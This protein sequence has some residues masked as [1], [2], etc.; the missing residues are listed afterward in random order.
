MRV[1]HAFESVL[2]DSLDLTKVQ[3]SHWNAEHVV[4]DVTDTP[5]SI[6]NFQ[7]TPI[8]S[9]VP[10]FAGIMQ[11]INLTPVPFGINGTDVDHWL[12]LSG[13]TGT[14]EAVKIVG[15]TAISGAASGTISFI[16]AFNHTGTW[17][18]SSA[19][20]GLQEGV[21]ASEKPNLFIPPGFHN[22]YASTTIKDGTHIYGCGASSKLVGAAPNLT[23]IKRIVNVG[24]FADMLFENFYMGVPTQFASSNVKGIH[25][26]EANYVQII[27]IMTDTVW[28]A[29]FLDTCS[30]CT[31]QNCFFMNDSMIYVGCTNADGDRLAFQNSIRGCKYYPTLA[32]ITIPQF[33]LLQRTAITT[34]IDL[35][36]QTLRFTAIGINCLNINEGNLF[37]DVTMGQAKVGIKFAIHRYPGQLGVIDYPTYTNIQ[38]CQIDQSTEYA[39]LWEAAFQCTIDSC[40]ITGQVTGS[41]YITSQVAAVHITNMCPFTIIRDNMFQNWQHGHIIL[42]SNDLNEVQI[43]NNFFRNY[44]PAGVSILVAP[45]NGTNDFYVIT[46]NYFSNENT[47]LQHIAFNSSGENVLIKDNLGVDT[48]QA[49]I[50]II[51]SGHMQITSAFSLVNVGGDVTHFD[52]SPS[53]RNNTFELMVGGVSVVTLKTGGNI[54]ISGDFAL[55]QGKVY[56]FNYLKVDNKWYISA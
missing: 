34:I 22:I 46:G 52:N 5:N 11:S 35:K 8:C 51:T 47:M 19:T 15:G 1:R 10:L 31:I 29:I 4:E 6:L 44:S 45:T 21:N 56:R 7:F 18:L 39:I 12:Y 36:I 48:L 25:I 24:S 37:F 33:I 16:P 30:Q 40:Y 32:T 53:Y 20:A 13:G 38:N 54:G 3:P 42:I 55:V 41:P 27:G 17:C 23:F 49:Q 28:W 2:P 9:S 14:A 43:I 50:G 26:Y